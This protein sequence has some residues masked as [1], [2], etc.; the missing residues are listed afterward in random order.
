MAA[1]VKP[2]PAHNAAALQCVLPRAAAR[3]SPQRQS[4]ARTK[5]MEKKRK[6]KA[7]EGL[8]SYQVKG[9][10]TWTSCALQYF[11]LNSYS[12]WS[13][14]LIFLLPVFVTSCFLPNGGSAGTRFVLVF[15]K[16]QKCAISPSCDEMALQRA[17]RNQLAGYI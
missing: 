6:K 8:T 16:K 2:P 13:P 12:A 14:T 10:G 11:N 3:V 15:A 5:D 4:S 7:S 1:Q 17:T 9:P